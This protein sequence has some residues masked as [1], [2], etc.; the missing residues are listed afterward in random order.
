MG[1]WGASDIRPCSWHQCI[2]SVAVPT[3]S[4]TIVSALFSGECSSIFIFF[5]FL[6]KQNISIQS[7]VHNGGAASFSFSSSRS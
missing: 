7:N 3:R 6:Q 2:S 5:L 1:G 4:L